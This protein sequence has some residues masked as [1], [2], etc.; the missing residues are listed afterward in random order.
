MPCVRCCVSLTIRPRKVDARR[1]QNFPILPATDMCAAEFPVVRYGSGV[2]LLR[3]A[4]L[5]ALAQYNAIEVV[6]HQLPDSSRLSRRIMAAA[7]LV[8]SGLNA[9]ATLEPGMIECSRAPMRLPG[10]ARDLGDRDRA[11]RRAEDGA[12]YRSL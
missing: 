1:C 5:V 9:V 4:E 6:N 8:W 3:V 11:R 2:F 7:Y 10:L 12:R